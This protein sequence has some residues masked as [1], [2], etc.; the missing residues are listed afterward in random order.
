MG[1]TKL[2]DRV[3]PSYTRGEELAN[4]ISHIVGA[5]MGLVALIWCLILARGPAEIISSIVY[6]IS[7]ILLY[8]TSS[9]YHGLKPPMAK[10][11]FQVLDH[12][13][14]YLYIAACYT[15]IGLCAVRQENAVIAWALVGVEWALSVVA[16][17]LTAIDIK[18][19]RHFSFTCY[20]VMGWFLLVGIVPV[21]RAL[22]PAGFVLLLTGGLL[23]TIG[24]IFYSAGK[25]LP[26]SHL[27]FHIFTLLGSLFQLLCITMYVL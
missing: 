7:M 16:I 25:K 4:M 20:I 11:V 13:M 27:V 22:G 15:V 5:V 3:M 6:G 12:C 1:R 14:I 18:M 8:T 19:F 17:T 2:I 21:Y 23:Y 24:A 26:Y 9:I 10:K